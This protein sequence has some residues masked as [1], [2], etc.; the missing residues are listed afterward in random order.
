MLK[1]IPKGWSYTFSVTN[2]TQ[3]VAEAVNLSWWGD[4]GELQIQGTTY[5]ASRDK[6]SYVLESTDGVVARAERPRKLF[7]ELIIEHSGQQY[8]LRAKS[9]FQREY[10]LFSGSTQIGS[11]SPEWLLS[12]KAEVELPNEFPLYLQIFII[13]LVMTLWK[14]EDNDMG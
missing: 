13:W 3:S 10:L 11:V 2:G 14:H 7:R 1:V 9:A 5:T 4:K 8:T 12:R 6:S